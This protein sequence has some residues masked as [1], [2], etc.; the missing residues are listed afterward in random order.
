MSDWP[1]YEKR[2]EDAKRAKERLD[3]KKTERKKD[4]VLP[5]RRE[6]LGELFD[7][8]NQACLIEWDKEKNEGKY[9]H[10]CMSTWES[11]QSML[12]DAGI[13]RRDQC[14]RP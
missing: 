13:L 8:Y 7:A 2:L 3:K 5:S 1:L 9:D 4:K 12:I 6:L 11:I 14:L 10:M